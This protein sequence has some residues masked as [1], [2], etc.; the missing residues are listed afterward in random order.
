MLD[1]STILTDPEL[2][3]AP[4]TVYRHTYRRERGESTPVSARVI[5]AEGCLHPA[6]PASLEQLPE[7]YRTSEILV[8]YTRQSL[9]MGENFGP[10]YTLADQL[11]ALGKRWRVI[12]VKN[13]SHQ[14]YFQAYAVRIDPEEPE[15]GD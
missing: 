3:A 8:I 1:I 6:V 9:S 14:G 15:N 7:E 12:K 10:I 13:W 11:E 5:Q 4:F 2:G